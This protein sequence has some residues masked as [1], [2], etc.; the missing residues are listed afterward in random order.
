MILLLLLTFCLLV[1]GGKRGHNDESYEDSQFHF[2]PK[3]LFSLPLP[4]A[5]SRTEHPGLVL[6]LR[7]SQR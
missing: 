6:S 4:L 7:P 3:N 2:I 5:D 1:S